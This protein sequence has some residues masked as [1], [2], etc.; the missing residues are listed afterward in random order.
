MRRKRR[1]WV[2]TMPIKE[3]GDKDAGQRAV[4]IASET[5]YIVANRL[6]ER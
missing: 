5:L 1:V 4:S 2:V 6:H 3:N